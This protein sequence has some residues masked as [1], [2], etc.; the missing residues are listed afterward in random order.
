M[1]ADRTASFQCTQNVIVVSLEATVL[2]VTLGS[3]SA[4]SVP[5]LGADEAVTPRHPVR[6]RLTTAPT[7]T[8]QVAPHPGESPAGP[9][10]LTGPLCV[11]FPGPN[12]VGPL[13][14]PF[15]VGGWHRAL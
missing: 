5:L 4:Q 6:M 9:A 1:R 12:P 8:R 14:R 7:N 11:L 15:P 3:H 13:P 2:Q 10:W